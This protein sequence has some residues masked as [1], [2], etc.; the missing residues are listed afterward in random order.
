MKNFKKTF[1]TLTI[2]C[3][4]GAMLT[5]CSGKNGI[6]KD[7]A[8][9]AVGAA[10]EQQTGDLPQTETPQNQPS[11]TQESQNQLPETQESQNQLPQTEAPQTQEFSQMPETEPQLP[12]TPETDFIAPE[13][14]VPGENMSTAGMMPL[15]TRISGTIP[16]DSVWYSFTTG[17]NPDAIYKIMVENT[18]SKQDSATIDISIIDEFGSKLG[19]REFIYNDGSIYTCSF[20]NA[21]PNT[22]YYLQ[23]TTRYD[24]E[25]DYNV[26]I[27]VK[28]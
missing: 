11:Q 1:T 27:K 12:K 19:G 3:M 6:D 8:N 17:I 7:F 23:M 20:E 10:N 18:T 15:E 21:E 25:C 5:G 24:D 13:D 9:Q 16:V 14:V 26:I 28:E 22:M 2:T 4:M